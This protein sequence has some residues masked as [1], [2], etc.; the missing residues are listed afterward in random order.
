PLPHFLIRPSPLERMGVSL[1]VL[2]PGQHHVIDVSDAALPRPAL[3]VPAVE[4]V[5]QQLSLVQPGGARWRQ[6]GSPPTATSSE[7]VPRGVADVAGATVMDQ[8]NRPKTTVVPSE[9]HQGCDVVIR[10]I[11]I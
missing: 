6:S 3:Q 10:V 1:I 8:V 11:G 7:I 2:R 9:P 5:I 4:G